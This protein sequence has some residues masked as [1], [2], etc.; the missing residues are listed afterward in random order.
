MSPGITTTV[1]ADRQ[2]VI[3]CASNA[4]FSTLATMERR[5]LKFPTL[6]LM[7]FEPNGRLWCAEGR[8]LVWSSYKN[9]REYS[10]RTLLRRATLLHSFSMTQRLQRKEFSYDPMHPPR[11]LESPKINTRVISVIA[12]SCPSRLADWYFSL[13]DCRSLQYLSLQTAARFNHR[14]PRPSICCLPH[15]NFAAGIA[16]SCCCRKKKKEELSRFMRMMRSDSHRDSYLP[17]RKRAYF[18]FLSK[19]HYSSIYFFLL[20]RLF[21]QRFFPHNI[22]YVRLTRSGQR[23]CESGLLHRKV[24]IR[25]LKR[26]PDVRKRALFHE[27]ET[28]K[29]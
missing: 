16:L 1:H 11:F 3:H 8:L 10:M 18:W 13:L 19:L 17:L 24:L 5:T 20:N 21:I 15:E 14:E 29:I 27:R 2:R 22:Y 28:L 26:P 23:N 25:I 7:P 6:R 9:N 4:L 12:S